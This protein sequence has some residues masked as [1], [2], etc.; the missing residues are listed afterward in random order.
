MGRLLGLVAVLVVLGAATVAAL[1]AQ[2]LEPVDPDAG[3]LLFEVERGDSLANITRALERRGVVRDA[4]AMEWWARLR[5]DASKLRAGEYRLSPAQSPDEILDVIVSG[6]VATHPVLIPEGLT[7]REIGARIAERGLV[8]GAAFVEAVGDPAFAQQLGIPAPSLE[9][10][11]FP[12][13]YQ[14]PRGLSAR[15]VAGLFVAQFQRAW[16][17]VEPA[18]RER[19]LT[20][21]EVV[22]LASIIEKETGAASERPLIASVFANRLRLQMRLESDPTVIYGIP[23]FDGN[24]RRSHLDDANNRYNTYSHAGLP[25]GPIANPGLD[26]LRAVVEP[27]DTKYLYF[28]SRND[29]THHFSTSYREH[30]AMVNRL[31]RRGAAR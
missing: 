26:S 9:G 25:P 19:G 10:Y 20:M 4:R 15:E 30:A 2:L 11:L 12:E 14:L 6:R 28:V 8:D 5:G 22:T 17:E 13:T 1:F 24:L 21:H 16:G 23:D 27:A 31:Q 29:G 7:A 18:A 3:E